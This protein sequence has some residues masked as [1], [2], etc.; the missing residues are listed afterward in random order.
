[1]LNLV[2]ED[3]AEPNLANALYLATASNVAY[4]DQS[5]GAEAFR[6]QLGL[7]AR[8][9]SVGN[10]QAFLATNDNHIVVAFRGTES[11]TS[12]EGL[13]DWLLTDANNFLILPEGR[14]GTDF[15]AAGVGTRYHKGFMTALADIWDPLFEA[16]QA[17]ITK[18]ERPLWLTGHSLGGALALL[19][20]W[21]FL[22]KTVDVYRIYT[23]G[24]PMVGNAAAVKAFDQELQGKVFRFVHGPDIVPHLPMMS[25][26]ANAYGHC[27]K[28]VPLGVAQAAKA[29]ESSSAFLAQLVPGAEAVLDA[30]RI[31]KIWDRLKQGISAH[32]IA[33]YVSQIETEKGRSSAG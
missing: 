11:P 26:I 33:G 21:R 10:T 17:E 5:K 25:L 8:L 6:S 9:F 28:E 24:G 31:D 20:A 27:L 2:M 23:F 14:I 22:R 29:A 12:V 32:D 3:G 19:A 4:L 16:T 15:V 30:V 13:K 18:K 1:M 7:E